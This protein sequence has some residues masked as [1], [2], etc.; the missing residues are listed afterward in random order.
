MATI[1]L[2]LAAPLAPQPFE[3]RHPSGQVVPVGSF[4]LRQI[5]DY[6]VDRLIEKA[7]N[8]PSKWVEFEPYRPHKT[9]RPYR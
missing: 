8:S 7:Q 4:E 9:Y 1:A 2:R 3:L 6:D 5:G